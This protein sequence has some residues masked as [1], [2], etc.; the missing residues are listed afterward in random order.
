[1]KTIKT[2]GYR[3]Q[4]PTRVGDRVF[5]GDSQH[6]GTYVK[7]TLDGFVF[8]PQRANLT[9]LRCVLV[10]LE[11]VDANTLNEP[12]GCDLDQLSGLALIGLGHGEAAPGTILWDSDAKYTP[13]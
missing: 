12:Y 11:G 4:V 1:M 5:I 2:S 8:S 6:R 7:L 9:V 10:R 3:Q 13:I